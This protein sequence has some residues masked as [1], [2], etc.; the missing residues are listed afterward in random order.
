[1]ATTTKRAAKKAARTAKPGEK[2]QDHAARAD[3]IARESSDKETAEQNRLAA[4]QRVTSKDSTTDG[5]TVAQ[6]SEHPENPADSTVRHAEPAEGKTDGSGEGGFPAGEYDVAK[7]ASAPAGPDQS[8]PVQAALD[9]H[10]ASYDQDAIDELHAS[11]ARITSAA[12]LLAAIEAIPVG[13][14]IEHEG[15]NRW[16][17]ALRGQNRY[18]HGQTFQLAAESFVLGDVI[19]TQDAAAKAFARL[20]AS[21]QAEIRE[22][23]KVASANVPGSDPDARAREAARTAA[24]AKP[25]AKA[26]AKGRKKK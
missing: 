13:G 3:A 10:L 7:P 4:E 2:E 11:D 14:V 1:M 16:R 5:K 23:D 20:P 18:G 19:T 24:L 15:L 21:Q 6:H 26:G 9:A 8:D 22:R 17:V 25:A 12:E